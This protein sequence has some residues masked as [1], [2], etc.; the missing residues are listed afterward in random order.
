MQ[1]RRHGRVA[2][3][4]AWPTIAKPVIADPALTQPALTRSA[5]AWSRLAWSR[6]A[7]AMLATLVSLATLSVTSEA[8]AFCGFYVS[9]ADAKLYNNATL[10]V[11]MREGTKTALSMQNSYEGPSE[12]F[13][14]VVPVPVVLKKDQVKTLDHDLF[15]KIDQ[16]AAP[17]LVEYWEQDPCDK[18]LYAYGL[19]LRGVGSGGGGMAE[20]GIG[21]AGSGVKVEA[22]FDVEEYEIV[23]L[24]AKESTGLESWL[25]QQRYRIPPGAAPALAPYIQQ[26]MY[27]FVARVNAKKVKTKVIGGE[28]RVVLSPLRVHYDSKDFSL[29]VRLGLLNARGKQDLLVHILS[30]QRRYE[31][32]NRPNVTIPTNLV[33]K[34]EV[35][36]R[37]GA[38]YATLFDRVM[39]E[40]PGAVVTEYAW[41]AS[42][43]DPCP[44][45]T[46][47]ARD[48]DALGGAVLGAPGGQRPGGWILTR[49]HARYSAQE[50]KEDLVFQ[51]AAPIVGGRGMPQG[52]EQ[53]LKRG[54]LSEQAASPG[55]LNSF[56]GR[57]MILHPWT[58]AVACEDPARGRWGGP[59]EAQG[60]T[61]PP[62]ALRDVAFAPRGELSLTQALLTQQVPGL[63]SP[64]EQAQ[65]QGRAA[66]SA[67]PS[68]TQPN[69]QPEPDAA[70]VKAERA[71]QGSGQAQP[72]PPAAQPSTLGCAQAMGWPSGRDLGQLV[73][74]LVALGVWRRGARRSRQA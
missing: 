34:P 64:P 22:R 57:Y 48:L 24:S 6:L 36:G 50:L 12:D 40:H 69:P 68:Q 26:G 41:D 72:E 16:L 67:K 58:G 54:E 49:L 59:P 62:Q 56:Q 7:W 32:A 14:M 55:P 38:F 8:R 1:A 11:L 71:S 9:G 44:G 47:S 45:P 2:S 51:E 17:R 42:T 25:R 65:G 13:A 74:L 4:L 33:L 27:F 61:Q 70:S 53:V 28:P 35:K 15:E 18:D 20:G 10:V 52:V 66:T 63:A 5:S 60:S 31:V 21:L 3:V 46:L 73:W 19:G 23:I 39:E 29:P 37:F 30:R 43:C